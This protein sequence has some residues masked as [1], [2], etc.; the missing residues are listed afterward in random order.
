MIYGWFI[1]AT[2]VFFYNLWP[3]FA[4]ALSGRT[5]VTS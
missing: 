3:R 5:T 1:A 2:F 4:A